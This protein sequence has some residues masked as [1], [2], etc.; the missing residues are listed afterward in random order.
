[1]SHSTVVNKRSGRATCRTVV[2][3]VAGLQFEYVAAHTLERVYKTTASNTLALSGPRRRLEVLQSSQ[4]KQV[5]VMVK[6]TPHML[7]IGCDGCSGRHSNSNIQCMAGTP[8]SLLHAKDKGLYKPDRSLTH[9]VVTE[10][11]KTS[12]KRSTVLLSSAV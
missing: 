4:Q 10:V 6:P 5:Y 9:Y 1:M 2:P 3:R 11:V 8:E 12:G 7:A